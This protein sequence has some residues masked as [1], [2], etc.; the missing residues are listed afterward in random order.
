MGRVRSELPSGAA[1][2]VDN[3]LMSQ[4]TV[5]LVRER[6]AD[7]LIRKRSFV[8]VEEYLTRHP[9]F[10]KALNARPCTSYR[11]S[12]FYLDGSRC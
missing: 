9:S 2:A 8:H 11:L 3:E 10:A 12:M 6:M 5:P 1:C 4:G 7:I